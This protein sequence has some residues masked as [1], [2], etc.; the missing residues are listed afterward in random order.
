MNRVLL[1]LLIAFG[2]QT[3]FAQ[4]F[5]RMNADLAGSHKASF[6]GES[7]SDDVNAGFTIAAE[8]IKRIESFGIGAG[9]EFQIPREVKGFEGK[10]NFV[11]I[12]LLGRVYF[13]PGSN[14]QPYLSVRAGYGLYFGDD[15]YTGG[16]GELSGGVYSNIGAG[17]EFRNA[18]IEVGFSQN[19]GT[20]EIFGSD[21]S[22]DYSRVNL[23]IGLKF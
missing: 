17:L 18:V 11:P 4:K 9:V 22:I 13:S 5:I 6:A 15:E 10:F 16:E 12:Y 21:V 1:M 19:S 14:M 23:G 3:A 7:S 2:C 8:G 20:F